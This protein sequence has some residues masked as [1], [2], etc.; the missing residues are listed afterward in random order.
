VVPIFLVHPREYWVK[1][2]I[3]KFKDSQ[4]NGKSHWLAI[5]WVQYRMLRYSYVMGG[6]PD[7]DWKKEDDDDDEIE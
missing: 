1:V 5:S 2:A 7:D 3:Y 6:R 4:Y